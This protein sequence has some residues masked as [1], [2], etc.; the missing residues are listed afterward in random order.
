[1]LKHFTEIILLYMKQN[2]ETLHR[3]NTSITVTGTSCELAQSLHNVHCYRHCNFHHSALDSTF[4]FQEIFL[5]HHSFKSADFVDNGFTC[6]VPQSSLKYSALLSV[7]AGEDAMS[8]FFF[9]RWLYT[10]IACM[11]MRDSII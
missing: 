7:L 1:M 6:G 8:S 4:T 5:V 2:V 9:E 10:A 11:M 3:N